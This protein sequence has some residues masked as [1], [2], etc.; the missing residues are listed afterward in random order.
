MIFK[1][2]LIELRGRQILIPKDHFKIIKKEYGET[3]AE[4]VKGWGGTYMPKP[5]LEKLKGLM[6]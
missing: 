1:V 6:N 4:T 2:T 5:T 3:F